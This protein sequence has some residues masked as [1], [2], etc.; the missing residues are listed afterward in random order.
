MFRMNVG[1][2]IPYMQHLAIFTHC[3]AAT[4]LDKWL[5]AEV[6]FSFF[7]SAINSAT[8]TPTCLTDG[9]M[10]KTIKAQSMLV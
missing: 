5:S 8:S 2:D 1:L 4:P 7:N 3:L 10:L 9:I 6:F